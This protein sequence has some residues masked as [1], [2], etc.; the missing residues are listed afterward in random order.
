L[1][2]DVIVISDGFQKQ[3]CTFIFDNTEGQ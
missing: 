3:V 1:I 2:I